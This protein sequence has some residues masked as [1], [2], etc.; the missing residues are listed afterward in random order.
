MKT[1]LKISP[2]FLLIFILFPGKASAYDD[3][4]KVIKKEYTVNPDARI[5]LENKFGQ[6]HCNNWD[7]NL[8][9]IEIR[10]TV[11]ASSQ[12][13]AEKLLDLVNIESEGT[14]SYVQT[15]TVFSKEGFSGNS[16]VNVDYTVN[17]P[18]TVNLN[19]T[20]K[21]GDVFLNDLSG[22][23]NFDISYGNIEINKL[24]N[25]DNVIDIKFG[26]GDVQ[27]ITGAMVSLKYSE[28]KVEYAGSLFV[29]SKFSNLKGNKIVS[30]SIGF[31]GG[32]VDV[33]NSS[34]VTGKSKFSDLSFSHL[35]KKIDLDIQYGNCDVDKIAADF[36]LISVRNKFGTV[37]VNIPSG[38]SYTLDAD[39]KFCDL[40]FPEDQAAIIQKIV[41][42]TSKSFRA[43]VGKNPN[44]EAK[45]IVRSEFGNVSLE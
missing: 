10:I 30:L 27:Y 9:S 26:K 44:P 15:R 34:A 13:K 12:E 21:F 14:P 35:D 24:M 37:S 36:T 41:T 40:D 31:E 20:N 16:K 38:T 1:L 29:D 23:G 17:M 6:I 28:M 42:N 33:E 11:T 39:L 8:V 2:V 19:L 45:V 25:S 4:T 3:Y 5:L 43:T 18:A 22:K 7:K 32:N